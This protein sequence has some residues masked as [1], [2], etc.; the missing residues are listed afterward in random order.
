[1]IDYGLYLGHYDAY[2]R[3]NDD[4]KMCRY[5]VSKVILYSF[6]LIHINR[7]HI[8]YYKKYALP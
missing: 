2:S 1:M 3:I 4:A 7:S 5:L 6:I 8:K